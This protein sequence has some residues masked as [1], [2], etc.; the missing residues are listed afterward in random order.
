MACEQQYVADVATAKH[1]AAHSASVKM[2]SVLASSWWSPSH[3]VSSIHAWHDIGG[4]GGVG[5]IPGE[6]GGGGGGALSQQMHVSPLSQ[7]PVFVP[8]ELNLSWPSGSSK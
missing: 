2:P 1:A 8:A 4:G 3:L 7:L 5:A 6:Y